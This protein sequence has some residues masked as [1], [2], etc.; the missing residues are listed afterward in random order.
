MEGGIRAWNGMVAKGGPETGMARFAAAAGPAELVAL[1]WGLEEGSRRFY[2]GVRETLADDRQGRRLFSELIEAENGHQQHLRQIYQQ[3][4]GEGASVET[5]LEAWG[6]RPGEIMEGGVAVEQA[7]AWIRDQE[8][9]DIVALAMGLEIN[10]YD[11]YIKMSRRVE[12]A[13]GKEIFGELAREEQNHLEWLG[14]LLDGYL[15]SS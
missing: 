1:A 5:F 15:R 2:Q 14:L 3:L 12:E 4:A 10:S 8:P 9:P 11:L 6:E 7:L 13:S